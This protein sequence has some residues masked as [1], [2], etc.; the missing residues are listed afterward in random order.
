[1]LPG[2][3]KKMMESAMKKLGVKQEPIDA[4]E[5]IIKTNDKEIVVRNPQVTKIN[6]MGQDTIQVIGDIEERELKSYTD[7]DVKTVMEQTNCSREEALGALEENSG[8]IA[9]AILYLSE[10]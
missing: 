5:V 8:D 1:M 6:M 4:V 2:M 7:E 3:N 9:A 10:K